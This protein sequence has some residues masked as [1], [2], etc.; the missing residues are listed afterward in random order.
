M[1][2]EKGGIAITA[3][4]AVVVMAVVTVVVA[5]VVVVV[6]VAVVLVVVA[7]LSPMAWNVKRCNAAGAWPTRDRWAPT[8]DRTNILVRQKT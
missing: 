3:V 1:S 5:F 7:N 6:V 2:L 8:Q 4:V